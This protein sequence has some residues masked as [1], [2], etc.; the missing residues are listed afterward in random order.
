MDKPN[1]LRAEWLAVGAA[2]L[3]M[4]A[5]ALF[6]GQRS[7]ATSGAAEEAFEQLGDA[8]IMVNTDFELEE[9]EP[10]TD[11][12]GGRVGRIEASYNGPDDFD[13]IQ[14][15]VFASERE[16]RE[17][18]EGMLANAGASRLPLSTRQPRF[19]G[20]IC[21]SENQTVKCSVR[22]YEAVVTGMAG[23]TAGEFSEENVK[24]NAQTLL[25]AGVKN[26][27]DARGLGLPEDA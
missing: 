25:M 4:A 2:I 18:W 6:A 24:F 20:Q 3:A 9:Q 12:F 26:W 7:G 21:T 10:L 22:I 1:R 14:I 23:I 27:L 15:D 16:A 13:V 11:G 5:V 17:R 19:D 8:E